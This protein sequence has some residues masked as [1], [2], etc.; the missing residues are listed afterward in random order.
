[1]QGKSVDAPRAI[2]SYRG[3]AIQAIPIVTVAGSQIAQTVRQI[4]KIEQA[5]KA[6]GQNIILNGEDGIN[7]IEAD[8]I[9]KQI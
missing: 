7:R 1:M 8:K 4:G 2:Y 9:L 3:E 6:G 5:A